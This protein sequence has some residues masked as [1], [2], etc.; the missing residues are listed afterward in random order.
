M[1]QRFEY[2]QCRIKD[3]EVQT[4]TD[5]LGNTNV[6]R[7][8]VEDR[9]VKPSKRFWNSLHHRFGFT[10]NIFRYFR[11]DEVFQRIS[12]VASNDEIRWCI[13]WGN[14]GK[15][16][17]TGTLLAVS[18]PGAAVVRHN[19]LVGLLKR[20][21]AESINYSAGTVRSVHSPRAASTFAIAGDKFQNKFV[22]ETPIDGFGKPSVYLSLL[23]LICWNGAI[24]YTPAFRS[25]L[26]VGRGGAGTDFALVRVLEG[27]NNEEGF[28]A[29]RQ[30]FESAARSW[31]SVHEVNTAYRTLARLVGNGGMAKDPPVGG[32]GASLPV[33]RAQVL[34]SFQK[35]NGD[36]AQTYGLANLDTL[37]VKRQRTL[38]AGCKV[39]DLLNFASELATHHASDD[40]QRPLQAF[41][42]GMIGNEYDLEGTASHF[43]DWR[44]FFISDEKATGTLLEA[45]RQ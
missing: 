38:P 6:E 33:P 37:S 4:S 9:P 21:D 10:H 8:L 15:G 42:G 3:I 5:K 29:L 20:Y 32:D 43:S 34:R 25:E 11:H 1:S 31:A 13:A 23:R 12:E 7:V 36:L 18:N 17:E 30:R 24:G 35:M 2:G 41:I 44:D 16:R 27:F 45:G 22:L 19:D 14:K 26:N 39:Y 28:A 40:G